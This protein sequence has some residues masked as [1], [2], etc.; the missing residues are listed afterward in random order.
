LMRAY[1]D[2]LSKIR[3]RFNQLKT[4]GDPGPGARQLMIQ[5]LEGSGSELADALRF[6]DEQMLVGMT[7]VQKQ[8]LRPLLVRPLMQA[9][10][11]VVGPTEAELNKIWNAQVFEPF[12]RN[13]STKYPFTPDS[14]VEA[15]ATEMAQ[16]FGADGAISKFTS[17]TLG[18]LVV[19][20]GDILTT[21][22]WADIGVQLLPEFSTQVGRW[23]NASLA[24][25]A[26][27]SAVAQDNT[28]T[29]TVFQIQPLPAPGMTEYSV[30]IDGQLLRYR[31]TPSQWNNFVWPN[32]QGN[33]GARITAVGFDGKT[34]E[35]ANHTGRFGLEKLINSAQRKKKENGVFE[36]AWTQAGLT[37]AV[38]LR[39]ISSPQVSGDGTAS[40]GTSPQGQGLRGVRLPTSVVGSVVTD[41]AR[42][43]IGAKP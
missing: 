29:Q 24:K 23:M 10:A 3:T 32:S 14:R 17:N 30:E 15:N 2:H 33:P 34:V 6:V 35:I 42:Q 5:T 38:D 21:R 41:P 40:G 11:V 43:Q 36:L 19:R 27:E 28:Q 16:I 37:V 31:N 18:P 9:Y 13:L 39:I 22:T 7:D 1:M 26:G 4:Q 12:Q 20:R 8:T 25:G